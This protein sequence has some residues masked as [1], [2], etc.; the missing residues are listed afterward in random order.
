MVPGVSGVFWFQVPSETAILCHPDWANQSRK[1]SSVQSLVSLMNPLSKRLNLSFLLFFWHFV[2]GL[3]W[4]TQT[5]GHS[6][7]F[8]HWNLNPKRTAIKVRLIPTSP[9]PHHLSLSYCSGTRCDHKHNLFFNNAPDTHTRMHTHTYIC[10]PPFQQG[11]ESPHSTTVDNWTPLA[12][13]IP[14]RNKPRHQQ[15][16]LA[17]ALS[18]LSTTVR[19]RQRLRFSWTLTT[20]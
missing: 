9:T 19:M 3:H 7:G 6:F 12:W 10:T 13:E 18:N 17:S 8:S 1:S 14:H 11:L 4:C 2:F 20:S 16:R 15:C 5:G